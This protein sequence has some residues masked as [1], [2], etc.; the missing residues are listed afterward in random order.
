MVVCDGFLETYYFVHLVESPS[1][2]FHKKFS[3]MIIKP[4]YMTLICTQVAGITFAEFAQH[5]IPH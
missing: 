4:K 5:N 3:T 1:L 2:T